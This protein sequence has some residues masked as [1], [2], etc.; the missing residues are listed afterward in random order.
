MSY[1]LL[2]VIV[3]ASLTTSLSGVSTVT[4]QTQQTTSADGTVVQPIRITASRAPDGRVTAWEIPRSRASSL[5][6]WNPEAAAP[7]LSVTDAVTTART[8]LTARNPQLRQIELFSIRLARVRRDGVSLWYYEINFY[9]FGATNRRSGVSLMVVLLTDGS[10]V[11][12][13][14]TD[15]DAPPVPPGV[16]QLGPGVTAPRAVRQP[17]PNYTA[18]AMKRGIVGSIEVTGIVGTD[19]I[20]R[21]ARIIRSLDAVYG[22]DQEALKTV[23]QWRFEPGIKDGRPVPVIMTIEMSF[24]LNRRP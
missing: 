1:A 16:Y 14:E 20:M 4:T 10:I 5:P 23:A 13:M 7:T 8:W 18:E 11:E 3:F 24:S 22:L 2:L 15:P 21:D 19:G 6:Q 17:T 9:E 12:P